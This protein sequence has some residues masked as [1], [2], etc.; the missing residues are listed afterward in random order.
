MAVQIG[1]RSRSIVSADGQVRDMAFIHL[2]RRYGPK[3][4]TGRNIRGRNS[5]SRSTVGQISG[6]MADL[7]CII[8]EG[9]SRRRR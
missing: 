3:L 9:G 8:V 7:Q 1:D 2:P 4:Y 5:Q 6:L